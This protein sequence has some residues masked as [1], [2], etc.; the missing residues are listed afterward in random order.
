MIAFQIHD[1]DIF[2]RCFKGKVEIGP[3]DMQKSTTQ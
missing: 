3:I 2:D 1:I